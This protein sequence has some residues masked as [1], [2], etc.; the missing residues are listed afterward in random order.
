MSGKFNPLKKKKKKKNKRFHNTVPLRY[1]NPSP[2]N[3]RIPKG[4]IHR[5]RNAVLLGKLGN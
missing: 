1:Q 3:P 4:S 2:Q 5:R